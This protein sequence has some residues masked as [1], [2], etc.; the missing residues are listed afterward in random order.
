MSQVEMR[1]FFGASLHSHQRDG[2]MIAWR[3]CT[4]LLLPWSWPS[5]CRLNYVKFNSG[6]LSLS[7]NLQKEEIFIYLGWRQKYGQEALSN[8]LSTDTLCDTFLV[9]ELFSAHSV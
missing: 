5:C 4:T 7:G 9:Y 6:M 8:F 1:D 3:I 2:E